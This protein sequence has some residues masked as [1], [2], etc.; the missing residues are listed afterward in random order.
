[1]FRMLDEPSPPPELPLGAIYF[2]YASRTSLKATGSTQWKQRSGPTQIGCSSCTAWVSAGSSSWSE[3]Y[4]QANA[5]YR[6]GCIQQ[7]HK[8]KGRPST[9]SCHLAPLKP[10]HGVASQPLSNCAQ[11]RGR[12]FSPLK[13][14]DPRSFGKLN[15]CSNCVWNNARSNST[16]R[17][18]ERGQ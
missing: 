12:T 17:F 3:C 2:H 18:E 10:L 9:A 16:S 4:S 1:M 5:T 15:V 7:S 14:W 11:P 8:P 13:L 6:L